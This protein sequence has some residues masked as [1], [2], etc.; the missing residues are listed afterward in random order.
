MKISRVMI[1]KLCGGLSA[2]GF[3]LFGFFLFFCGL[4]STYHIGVETD[5]SKSRASA[6]GDSGDTQGPTEPLTL[7]VVTYNIQALWVV[8]TNR[9]ARMKAIAAKLVELDPDIAGLQEVFVKED[10]DL[11]LSHLADSRLKHFQYYPSGLVGSGLLI[12]SAYPI[13]EVFF[14]RYTAA[15]DWY[16]LWEGDWW[17]GKGVAL[18]RIEL[19]DGNGWFDFY[20]THAQADYGDPANV[21]VR[22]TQMAELVDFVNESHVKGVPGI[23]VGD[24]NCSIGERDYEIAIKGA[25]LVRAMSVPSKIDHIFCIDSGGYSFEVLD[26]VELRDHNGVRLSDHNGYVSDIRIT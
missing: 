13:K 8:G 7:R 3:V 25:R 1:L 18:A 9:P 12:A 15:G 19:P 10:R 20:T 6:S 4:Y 24:V 26:S 2:I 23:L 11:L 5:I 22:T 14:H 16:K 17:A 21:D